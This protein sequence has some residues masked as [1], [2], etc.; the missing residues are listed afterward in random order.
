[1]KDLRKL[2][3]ALKKKS[4]YRKSLKVMCG[5]PFETPNPELS[6]EE[7]NIV[8]KCEQSTHD[9]TN[10]NHNECTRRAEPSPQVWETRMIQSLTRK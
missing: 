5:T 3:S 7:L 9:H 8:V 10:Q 6:S 1:M 2:P 4:I